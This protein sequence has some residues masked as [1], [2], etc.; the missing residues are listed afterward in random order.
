MLPTVS[1]Q[2]Q[3]VI[4]GGGIAGLEALIA[5][6]DLAGDRVALTLVAPDREF[7]YKPFTVEEPFSFTPAE[8]HELE[9]VAAEFGATFIEDAVSAV[10]SESH[11]VS[12]RG[13]SELPFDSA[14]IC[15]GARQIPPFE[16]AAT[17][18]PAGEPVQMDELLRESAAAEAARIAFVAPPGATWPLPVYELALMARRRTD[19]LGLEGL[20]TVI[21]TPEQAPLI[22][23]GRPASEA[24]ASLLGA[25]GIRVITSAR[26]TAVEAG[27]LEWAPGH[28]RLEVGRVVSLPT[29]EGP[30]IEGLPADERGFIPIDLHAR[31][32]GVNDVYAAG[33]GTNFPIKQ[34]GLATQEADAAAEHIAAA[35]GAA[36]EPEPFHPVLHGRL[37]TG[38]ES[39]SLSADVGGGGGEGEVSLDYLWWPPHK[40][41]GRYLPA[42]LAGEEPRRDPEPPRHS[43]EVEVALPTEWHREPMALDPYGPPDVE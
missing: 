32:R 26:V 18:R 35:A 23:F 21:L 20:E 22:M 29:L 9:P 43:I 33:D 16:G 11:A 42:W 15:V 39:L 40:V 8:R 36:I 41:S 19:E 1:D 3:V 4:A 5:L 31:V 17:F 24:V 38:D 13:G 28:E 25:R 27:A 34:G 10:D 6:R 37:L 30:A 7:T 2:R 12:L 14:L